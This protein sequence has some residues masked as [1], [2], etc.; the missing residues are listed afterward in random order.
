VPLDDKPDCPED[1]TMH[2]LVK[3]I[4]AMVYKH[5]WRQDHYEEKREGLHQELFVFVGLEFI[6][7]SNQ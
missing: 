5:Y 1:K 4:V 7:F 6:Q 2:D 3:L